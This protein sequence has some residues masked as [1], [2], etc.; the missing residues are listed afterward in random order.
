[1]SIDNMDDMSAAFNQVISDMNKETTVHNS[2][3]NSAAEQSLEAAFNDTVNGWER[4]A[5]G[6]D[7]DEDIEDSEE[8]QDGG[9]ISDEDEAVQKSQLGDEAI[10]QPEMRTPV[11][12]ASGHDNQQLF[13]QLLQEKDNQLQLLYSRLNDLS[14]Q[15][16]TLKE[17][18]SKN[19]E[20]KEAVPAEVQELY[21]TY[22]ELA[23]AID[24]IVESKVN[25]TKKTIEETLTPQTTAMQQQ[26]QEMAQQQYVSKIMQVHPDLPQIM[27]SNSLNKW[28]AGMSDP[29][30]RA[31]A[32]WITRY[33]TVDNV[34]QLISQYKSSQQGFST[35]AQ[36]VNNRPTVTSSST[37][38]DDLVQ[39]IVNAISVPSERQ[40][41]TP[42]RKRREYATT[43]EAFKA[44]ANE[45]ERKNYRY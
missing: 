1:M 26:L 38:D 30:Q 12:N 11:E 33:G 40:A 15:Y 34:V 36:S 4:N 42:T 25:V 44:L 45:Y 10:S 9:S 41:P 28:I 39:K 5:Y 29:V 21:E 23:T 8:N 32:E 24:K 18:T 37:N 6:S 2:A 14:S 17:E 19:V 22:P 31:G 3:R 7:I 27:Q 35:P 13:S 16:K 43:T 20:T